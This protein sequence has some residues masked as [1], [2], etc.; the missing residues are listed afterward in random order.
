MRADPMRSMKMMGRVLLACGWLVPA[1]VAWHRLL[2]YLNDDLA[3]LHFKSPSTL[4]PLPDIN[5]APNIAEARRWMLV[6]AVWL[7]AA[8]LGGCM[9]WYRARSERMLAGAPADLPSP[10]LQAQ[11]VE[12]ARQMETLT[13]QV[14]A[15]R[16]SLVGEYGRVQAMGAATD[17]S[18]RDR[19]ER[20]EQR[21]SGLD[22]A[23]QRSGEQLGQQIGQQIGHQFGDLRERM[24]G[25][26]NQSNFGDLATGPMPLLA[27]EGSADD[28]RRLRDL[29]LNLSDLQA[30]LRLEQRQLRQ[31]LRD[32]PDAQSGARGRPPKAA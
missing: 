27:G 5:E 23:L 16:E 11:H 21:L 13:R 20:L 2:D 10:A 22:T 14:E 17:D 29:V 28:L 19:F 30:N 26:T 7:G 9:S 32:L 1:L 31:R 18:L 24:S 8:I 4:L 15:C 6:A 25:S 12:L 3:R